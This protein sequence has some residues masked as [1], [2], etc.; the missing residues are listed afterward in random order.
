[1]KI[2]ALGCIHNDV[3]NLLRFLDSLSSI[4]FDVL[5]CPGDFTDGALPR[6]FNN[7]EITKLI[8]EEFKSLGKPVLVV[9]GSWDGEL[10]SIFEKENVSIHGKGK[11]INGVGFYGFGGAKTP[12]GLPLEPSED[13]LTAGLKKA[14]SDVAK[15]KIKIQITH[16]P[17]ANTKIDMIGSGAHVGSEAVRKFLE[18]MQPQA[19]I[20]AHIHESRGVDIIKNTKIINPGR[21]PEGHF[22][23]IEINGN[24]VTAKVVD[25]I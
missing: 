25:L 5:V 8:L 17:P 22:G 13:E 14:Y 18:E 6:G 21:F 9:P 10:I 15:A 11:I 24:V 3:E 23:F 2:V 4:T 19:A 20:S 1:M 12:F 16:A 7:I